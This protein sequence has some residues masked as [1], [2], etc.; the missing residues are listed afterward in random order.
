MFIKNKN[1]PLAQPAGG[2]G[3]QPGMWGAVGFAVVLSNNLTAQVKETMPYDKA[4]SL[5]ATHRPFRKCLL[6]HQSTRL[7]LSKYYSNVFGLRVRGEVMGN[8]HHPA[9]DERY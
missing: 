6:A 4:P 5:E 8:T 2:M 9:K 3:L 7:N 1:Q